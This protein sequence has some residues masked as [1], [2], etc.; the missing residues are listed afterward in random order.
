MK[1]LLKTRFDESL[2]RVNNIVDI[3]EDKLAGDR[4]GRRPVGSTDILRSAVVFLHATVEEFLR[5]ILEWQLPNQ[6]ELTLNGIPLVGSPSGRADKFSLGRLAAHRGKTVD[7]LIEE[8]VTSHL[9]R[10]NFNSVDEV[11]AA[12]NSVGLNPEPCRPQFAQLKDLMERRHQIVHR[13]DRNP[14]IGPGQQAA[15]SIGRHTVREWAQAAQT[16]FNTVYAQFP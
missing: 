6:A 9:T 7:A 16:F 8:S 10:S 2:A 15:T 3:Y 4:Q 13:A 12:L 14:N 1:A 11:C 5:G